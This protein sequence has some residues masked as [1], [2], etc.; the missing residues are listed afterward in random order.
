MAESL[1]Q[2]RRKVRTRTG[3]PGSDQFNDDGVIDDAVNM[4]IQSIESEQRWPWLQAITPH[5]V[6]AGDP[7]IVLPADWRATRFL[8]LDDDELVGISPSDLYMRPTN[9]HGRP[10]VYAI[11]GSEIHVRPVPASEFVLN[12]LYYR[13][14]G[15]L[16][17]DADTVVL[18]DQFV[19]AIVAKAA[20]LLSIREDDRAAAA[21]HLAEYAQW[22]VRMRREARRIS[23]PLRVRVREGSWI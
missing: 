1:M 9:Q 21:S 16:T 11:I 5:T 19:G 2:I 15:T 18:P 14:A 10:E 20:E 8:F 6:T 4:A 7:T 23:G 12:H 13:T 3:T 17:D 22:V